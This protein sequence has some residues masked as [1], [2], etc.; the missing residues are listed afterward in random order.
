MQFICNIWRCIFENKNPEFEWGKIPF[1]IQTESEDPWK[2][3]I[4]QV[5]FDY[6]II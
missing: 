5:F 1:F 4:L 2:C 6:N 3:L